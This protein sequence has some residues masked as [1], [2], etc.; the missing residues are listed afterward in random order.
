MP[1]IHLMHE[2]AGRYTPSMISSMAGLRRFILAVVLCH[3]CVV[4][5]HLVVVANIGSV[6]LTPGFSL[7]LGVINPLPFVAIAFAERTI[8]PLVRMVVADSIRHRADRW[9]HLAFL[10]SGTRQRFSHRCRILD[11]VVPRQRSPPGRAGGGWMLAGG[12]STEDQIME[13]DRRAFL[14]AGGLAALAT[15]APAC[16]RSGNQTAEAPVATADYTIRIATGLVDL[17][18][19]HIVSTT[20]YNDQFPGPLLRFKEGQRVVVDVVNDT[21]TPEL[22]HWHGQMVPSDVDGA[23]EEARRSCPHTGCDGSRSCLARQGFASI[24]RTSW[25]VRT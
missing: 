5:W 23:S 22:L 20:L 12:D 17:G 19:G 24:T 2:A 14:K 15:A 11:V 1:A 10:E 4:V 9:P 13:C 6:A 8:R 21:D 3:A 18:P 7:V 16:T 25:R